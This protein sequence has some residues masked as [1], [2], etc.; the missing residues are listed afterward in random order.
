[1]AIQWGPIE[2]LLQRDS[3]ALLQDLNPPAEE[4]NLSVLQQTLSVDLPQDF[5]DFLRGHD[6]QKGEEDPLFGS[7]EFLSS[8]RI[9]DAWEF[10]KG[11]SQS[12]S[13]AD[14]QVEAEKGVKSIWWD[15]R[16]VP[17]AT[18]GSGDYMCLDMAPTDGGTTGQ[19]ISVWHD[20]GARK[21]RDASFAAWA[22]QF[23]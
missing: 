13:T 22:R 14:E 23:F 20:D 7:Y 4:K 16:W 6:G 9:L 2:T 3:P 1:M 11:Q 12:S 5:L 19:V 8:S 21:I 18:N 10:L 17:F 15:V